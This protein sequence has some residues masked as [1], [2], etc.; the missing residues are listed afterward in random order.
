MNNISIKNYNSYNFFFVETTSDCNLN[1]SYCYFKK[2]KKKPKY[3]VDFLIDKLRNFDHL[4]ICFLGGEP[5]LNIPFMKDILESPLLKCKDILYATN[6]NGTLIDQMPSN[7]L[8]KFSFHH[9]SIDGYKHTHDIYRGSG[10]YN[11]I[12]DNLKYLKTYS[13]AGIVARMTITQPDQILD[14]PNFCNDFDAVYWQINNTKTSLPKNFV[15]EYK[16]SLMAIFKFWQ[17]TYKQMTKFTIIPIIGLCD[18]V[19]TGGMKKPNLLC[20]S[21]TNHFNV[22]IDGSVYPCPE[23]PNRLVDKEKLG[24]LNKFKIRIYTYKKR[25]VDCSILKYCGGRCAMTDDDLY[26]E[27]VFCLY[28]LVKTFVSNLSA[29]ELAELKKIIEFQ[30]NLAYTTEIIP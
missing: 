27:C 22:C 8:S 17:D 10:V 30:K 1:C 6:T 20:G 19:L 12:I 9:L 28:E 4:I 11:K 14:I 13:N 16:K 2:D 3:T 5:F 21:G 15:V 26:C 24:D 25:C 23:S 7:L 18:L 29:D